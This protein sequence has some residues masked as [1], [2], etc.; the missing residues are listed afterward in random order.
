MEAIKAVIV[1]D[2]ILARTVL[3]ADLDQY[4]PDVEV[5]GEAD[6]VVDATKIINSLS[7]DLVFLDIEMG[8]HDGF[9]LVE[10]LGE[11][12]PKVIFVTGS[13]DYAVKAF[14]IEAVDY[15]LKPI[16]P[17]L[18]VK[19]IKRVSPHKN[20]V[21]VA[22]GKIVLHTSDEVRY[23]EADEIIRLEADGNYT[24]IYFADGSHLFIAKT[25]KEFDKMLVDAFL[26]VHQS[27]LVNI[28]YIK[29]FVKTEGGYLLLKN[30]HQVPVSVRKRSIILEF[31]S[32]L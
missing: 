20:K 32:K 16:D 11:S 25:L 22:N 29:S 12:A 10:M 21:S 13:K 9:D 27:H 28:D 26:R 8:T 31:L 24:T 18:L 15:L 2:V 4:C 30:G 7:P 1:D 6:N 5:I 23:T 3:K 14:Q 17:Q 19:A